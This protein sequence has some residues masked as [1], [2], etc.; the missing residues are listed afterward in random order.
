MH[1]GHH[2]V[3]QR[4]R[5]RGHGQRTRQ[6]ARHFLR[7]GRAGQGR[8]RQPI[9]QHLA[10]HLVRQQAS[11]ALETLAQPH[12]IGNVHILELLEQRPQAGYRAGRDQQRLRV[13]LH[14]LERLREVAADAQRRWQGEAG[15]VVQ[16]FAGL[17]HGLHGGAI[18]APDEHVVAGRECERDSGAPGSGA[19]DGDLA[20]LLFGLHGAPQVAGVTYPRYQ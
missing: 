5:R 6:A 7:E 13:A 17:V 18:A 20:L 9:A 2:Q 3:A 15:Q 16:V 8:P 1:A 12:D 19:E 4:F 14:V 10:Q 11:A